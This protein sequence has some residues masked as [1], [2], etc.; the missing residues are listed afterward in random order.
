MPLSLDEAF[1]RIAILKGDLP[2]S[3]KERET[4]QAWY[5]DFLN[6]LTQQLRRERPGD[7]SVTHESVQSTLEKAY[8]E[9]RRQKNQIATR[10]LLQDE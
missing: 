7:L 6:Q 3:G 10:R 2:A 8:R 4:A 1:H 9:Y 5:R